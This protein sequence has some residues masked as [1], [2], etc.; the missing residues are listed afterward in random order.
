M[1]LN[2]LHAPRLGAFGEGEKVQHCTEVRGFLPLPPHSNPY[3][4][5]MSDH[6]HHQGTCFV[7]CYTEW[8]M[9]LLPDPVQEAL[10]I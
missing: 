1:Q 7:T 3:H 6:Q 10:D 2:S 5:P 9:G 4:Y 8:S